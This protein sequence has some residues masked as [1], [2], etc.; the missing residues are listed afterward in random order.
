MLYAVLGEEGL[1]EHIEES[2]SAAVAAAQDDGAEDVVIDAAA[3]SG[4][5]ANPTVE[6]GRGALKQLHLPGRPTLA[7]SDRAIDMDLTEAWKRLARIM[8]S[9]KQTGRT[10]IQR[11][12]H[13]ARTR[14][15]LVKSFLGQ[16]AKTSKKKGDAEDVDV[17]G[18]NL[19]PYWMFAETEAPVGIGRSGQTPSLTRS[20]SSLPNLCAGSSEACRHSCLVFSGQNYSADW[21]IFAKFQKTRALFED[22]DAFGRVLFEACKKHSVAAVKSD[23]MPA[24][25]L[26]VLSDIP[27]EL[28]FPSLFDALPDLQFYDYTK[29]PGREPPLNYD[30]TFSNS[31]GNLRLV[32]RHIAEGGRVAVVAHVPTWRSG[33][34]VTKKRGEAQ[35]SYDARKE[36]AVHEKWSSRLPAH[37]NVGGESI[38]V[39]D[40]DVNDVRFLDPSPSIVALRWKNPGGKQAA[41]APAALQISQRT[42]FVVEIEQF[43]GL[44]IGAVTPSEQP[45][46]ATQTIYSVQPLQANPSSKIWTTARAGYDQRR[47]QEMA[48]RL[49]RGEI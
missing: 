13:P 18:V 8:P 22:P 40:G 23:Y 6:G 48:K 37:C 32:E 35:V 34:P 4:R 41:R 36:K 46:T 12:F 2:L 49:A 15:K 25:R 45:D 27:W 47:S 24:I 30:L 33:A 43:C 28:V 16:N 9:F 42:K 39:I 11:D 44:L 1:V 29:V 26:N 19:T 14:A 17:Q 38:R 21:S 31:G 7:I 10:G 3:P 20:Q 5:S